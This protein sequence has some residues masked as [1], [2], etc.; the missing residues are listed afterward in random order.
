MKHL[1]KNREKILD[2]ISD[3]KEPLTVKQI[4]TKVH[5]DISTVYRAVDFLEASEYIF[6][7]TFDNEKYYFKDKTGNFI[8]CNSCKKVKTF[9]F[10]STTELEEDN[11]LKKYFDFLPLSHIYLVKGICKK[12]NL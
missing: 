1:T 7:A 3:S 10:H 11:Y 5:F 4:K 8:I 2:I 6:S 12:C 9:P